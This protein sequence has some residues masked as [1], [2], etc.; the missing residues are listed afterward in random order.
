MKYK[1]HN[2]QEEIKRGCL[3]VLLPHVHIRNSDSTGISREE[4]N[5]SL[6]TNAVDNAVYGSFG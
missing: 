4:K 5:D 3:K 2:T 1:T 6:K